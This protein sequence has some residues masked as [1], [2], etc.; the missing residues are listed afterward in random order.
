MSSSSNNYLDNEDIYIE[1]C[2]WKFKMYVMGNKNIKATDKLG[3]AIYLTTEGL[4]RH[5]SFY[6]YTWKEDMIGNGVESMIKGMFNFNE[7]EYMNP[8]GYISKSAEYAFIQ[9]KDKEERNLL[10]TYKSFL[11]NHKDIM[12]DEGYITSPLDIQYVQDMVDRV[13]KIEGRI[14]RDKTRR[15][16]LK[17]KRELS[18][19]AKLVFGDDIIDK[20]N[21]EIKSTE[22]PQRS[23]RVV[24]KDMGRMMIALE[25]I[26]SELKIDLD[27]EVTVG[28]VIEY[29]SKFRKF[30]VDENMKMGDSYVDISFMKFEG[31]DFVDVKWQNGDFK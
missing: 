5:T 3:E 25:K 24:Y 28:D 8:H 31:E 22:V 9:T 11:E 30:E 16:L 17:L 15:K 26:K 14:E 2:H 12:E 20:I 18:P 4:G 13:K 10:A 23:V 6:R 7:Q 29:L 1:I 27:C 21:D 19:L